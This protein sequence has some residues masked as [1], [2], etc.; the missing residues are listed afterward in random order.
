MNLNKK[1]VDAQPQ[2]A[3]GREMFQAL[4]KTADV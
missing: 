4:A 3:A 2:V 1:S